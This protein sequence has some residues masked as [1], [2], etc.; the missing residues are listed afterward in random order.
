MVR[1]SGPDLPSGR[2]AASTGQRVP[3][4]VL[5]EQARIMPVARAVATVSARSSS[6]PSAGSATKMTSTSDT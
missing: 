2:R 5:A 3:S 4:P 6:T 1:T